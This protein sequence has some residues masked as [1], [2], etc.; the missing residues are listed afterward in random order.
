V[1]GSVKVEET[2]PVMVRVTVW[3]KVPVT[4]RETAWVKVSAPGREWV[5]APIAYSLDNIRYFAPTGSSARE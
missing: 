5:T 3:V 4:V 1:T 2:V